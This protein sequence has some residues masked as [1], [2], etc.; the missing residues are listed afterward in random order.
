MTPVEGNSWMNEGIH[1]Q[2]INQSMEF[3]TKGGNI[4]LEFKETLQEAK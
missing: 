4:Y 3:L 1:D 2:S